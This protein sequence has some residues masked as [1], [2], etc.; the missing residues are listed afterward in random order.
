MKSVSNEPGSGLPF[1]SGEPGS[2]PVQATKHAEVASP[3]PDSPVY[4]N[5]TPPKP[6]SL[7]YVKNII[8][9]APKA[10]HGPSFFES[11]NIVVA[12][13]TGVTPVSLKRLYSMT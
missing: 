10:L 4:R 6:R 7:S 9:R 8:D 2:T 11:A 13:V 5:L 1:A 12:V 3:E